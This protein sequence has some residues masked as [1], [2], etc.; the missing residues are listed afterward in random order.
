MICL[1]VVAGK[2]WRY[3]LSSNNVMLC[4]VPLS[5][6]LSS[7]G[8]HKL[9]SLV[10]TSAKNKVN[11]NLCRWSESGSGSKKVYVPSVCIISCSPDTTAS[12]LLQHVDLERLL[13]PVEW[14][15]ALSFQLQCCQEFF[16]PSTSVFPPLATC[17][18]ERDD[19]LCALETTPL[20]FHSLLPHISIF[21]VDPTSR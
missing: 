5:M 11:R 2:C 14:P 19:F 1:A 17:Q 9:S 16:F 15:E 18:Y 21:F 6:M 13:S 3:V 4:D 8:R 12:Q 10:S 20:C 7:V